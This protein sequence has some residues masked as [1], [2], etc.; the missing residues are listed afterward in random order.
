MQQHVLILGAQGMLGQALVAVYAADDAYEITAWDRADVDVTDET[1]LQ[2]KITELWPDIIIN[3]TAYNAVDACEEDDAEYAKAKVLN[4]DVPGAL[5][6]IAAD[7]QAMFVHYSTDYVFDGERPRVNGKPAPTCCGQRCHG[8][9]YRGPEESIDFRAYREIDDPHPLS[10][11]GR[12]KLMGE[13]AVARY[14]SQYYIIRLSKLFGAPAQAEGAKKSFFDVML[15]VGCKAQTDGTD[16]RVVDDETSCFTYAP[17]LAAATKELIEQEK[18]QGI[19]HIVNSGACTWYE[20]VRELYKQAGLSEVT[21]VPVAVQDF[22]RP[23]QR[24]ASSV[25]RTKKCTPLRHY[26]L[27]LAEHLAQYDV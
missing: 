17:D 11:Y 23:A 6:K 19:Y 1:A 21:I 12:T 10:R 2:T 9:Q 20:A 4:A 16:V 24:P 3:A 27:A 15:A 26:R 18:E 22:P 5:A 8:C 14:G 25:L 13:Q 7:L